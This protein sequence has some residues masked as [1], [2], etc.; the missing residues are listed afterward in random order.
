MYICP[1]TEFIKIPSPPYEN[2]FVLERKLPIATTMGEDRMTSP[3]TVHIGSME[4]TAQCRN[5]R[6]S[7]WITLQPPETTG[8][9]NHFVP[10]IFS[11]LP[12]IC[13]H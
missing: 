13:V 3:V 5:F 1:Q 12:T 2:V 8:L 10:Y 7:K 4:V 11:I 9:L 6:L